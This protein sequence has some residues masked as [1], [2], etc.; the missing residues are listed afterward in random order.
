[1]LTYENNMKCVHCGHLWYL[2]MEFQ[3][4]SESISGEQRQEGRTNVAAGSA[5]SDREGTRVKPLDRVWLIKEE[6]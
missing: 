5:G 2:A 1:M 6:A 3:G 4:G